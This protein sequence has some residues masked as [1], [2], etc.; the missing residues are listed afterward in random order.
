MATVLDRPKQKQRERGELQTQSGTVLTPAVAKP[1]ELRCCATCQHFS[2]FRTNGQHEPKDPTQG[3]GYCRRYPP[4][5]HTSVEL[6]MG[7]GNDDVPRA[8]LH[9]TGWR[10]GDMTS[11]QIGLLGDKDKPAVQRLLL[12]IVPADFDCGEYLRNDP[13]AS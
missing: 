4:T 12:P 7:A 5:V 8:M 13:R 3:Q 1:V 10:S 6:I 11:G 9:P 2:R